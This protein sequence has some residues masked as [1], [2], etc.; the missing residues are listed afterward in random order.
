M[1][2]RTLSTSSSLASRFARSCAVKKSAASSS[3]SAFSTDSKDEAPPSP[4]PKIRKFKL[5]KS[6]SSSPQSKSVRIYT[7]T[8]DSGNSSLYTG[9]RRKK[10]D[11]IFAALGTTDELAS[12]IGKE[13]KC[14]SRCRQLY[15]GLPKVVQANRY[16]R[17]GNKEN[18][19][20]ESQ[21]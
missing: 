21:V 6:S 20:T 4:S 15:Q 16:F 17:K 10:S 5:K 13:T 18:E 19:S 2:P 9:E 1:L 7:R 11:Q 8:G 14:L 12:H 3:S